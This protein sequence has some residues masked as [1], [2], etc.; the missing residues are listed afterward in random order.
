[1]AEIGPVQEILD[2]HDGVVN[3]IDTT[4]GQH[5]ALLGRRLQRMFIHSDDR[6]ANLLRLEET[7]PCQRCHL[8]ERRIARI[9]ADLH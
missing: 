4:D 8:R 5:Y 9:H 1:M 2:E 3:V 7:G 6:H